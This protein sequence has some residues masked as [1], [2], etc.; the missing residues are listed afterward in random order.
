MLTP[1]VGSNT[2]ESNARMARRCLQ[3]IR[4]FLAGRREG[5]DVVLTTGQVTG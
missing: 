2:A 3:N 1:H 4:A 5:M